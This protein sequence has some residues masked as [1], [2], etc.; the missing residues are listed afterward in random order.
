MMGIPKQHCARGAAS[1]LLSAA[2][3]SCAIP[4]SGARRSTAQTPAELQRR[5]PKARARIC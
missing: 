4:R 3:T 5:R 1:F 2:W